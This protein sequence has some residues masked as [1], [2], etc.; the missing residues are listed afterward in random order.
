MEPLNHA[1]EV[2]IYF[3]IFSFI[4][5]AVLLLEEDAEVHLSLL[6]HPFASL[7]THK[8]SYLLCSVDTLNGKAL[9]TRSNGN[10]TLDMLGSDRHNCGL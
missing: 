1:T 8:M 4:T 6:K 3:S 9:F 10:V 2:V 5:I 7:D